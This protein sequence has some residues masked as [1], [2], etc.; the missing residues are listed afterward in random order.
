MAKRKVNS[1]RLSRGE[2]ELLEILWANQGVTILQ[3]QD[4]LGHKVGY[5]TVQTRLD[6]LV[7]KKL[8]TK[9]KDR[10][11]KYEAAIRREQVSGDDLSTLLNHVTQGQVVPLIAHLLQD[12]QLTQAEIAE[13]RTLIREAEKKRASRE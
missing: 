6:R 5:T 7:G 13:V 3:V 12:R 4:A 10:P 8:A 9:T 11:G 2:I 1:P